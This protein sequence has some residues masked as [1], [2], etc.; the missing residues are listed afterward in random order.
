MNCEKAESLLTGRNHLSRKIGNN[1]YLMRRQDCYGIK[2]H[3]TDVVTIHLG[4][5]YT[6]DS[7]G[8][9]TSTTKDRINTYT[10]ARI[11]QSKGIWYMRDGSLFYDGVTISADGYPLS[12]KKPDDYE[13]AVK[14]IK[15]RVSAYAKAFDESIKS[16]GIGYPSGGDCWFCA[17][18]NVGN[19]TLGD[20]SRTQD[21]LIAHMDEKYYVPSLLFNAIK[22]KNYNSPEFIY[23]MCKGG[24]HWATRKL[25][26]EYVL[27]RMLPKP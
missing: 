18:R 16:N 26:Y 25:V 7:G 11:S 17:M 21:H 27:K 20:I 4:G 3:E 9:R 14:A 12:P 15:K 2:L 6:L 22:E 24:D 13:K 19:M 8:W 1:T 10:N 23:E 5:N